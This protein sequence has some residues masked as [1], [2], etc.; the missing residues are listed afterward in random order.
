M[1][2]FERYEQFTVKFPPFLFFKKRSELM[3]DFESGLGFRRRVP[4]QRN[5]SLIVIKYSFV[6]CYITFLA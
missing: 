2:L 4:A 6:M 5:H 3:Y 1:E